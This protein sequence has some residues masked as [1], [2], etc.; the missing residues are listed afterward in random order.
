MPQ[1]E[2]LTIDQS[3]TPA[4]GPASWI[5]TQFIGAPAWEAQCGA[6]K[7]VVSE[8]R[9]RLLYFGSVD[10]SCNLLCCPENT[11]SSS[12]GQPTSNWG[13]HRFWLGPQKRWVWPP[14]SDW[15]FSPAA[16]VSSS[17]GVLHLTHP[18][19]ASD[20]PTIT[21]EYAFEAGRLRCTA[22]WKDD[23]RLYYG[24]HVIAVDVPA[25]FTFKLSKSQE[26]P[27]GLVSVL[28]D[29]YDTRSLG[30]HP[31][32]REMNGLGELVSGTS[33]KAKVGVFPQP[34]QIRREGGWLLSL[35]PGPH[36]GAAVGCSDSG[37][38]SQV[39]V[40]DT[41]CVFAEMEQISPFLAGDGMGQCSS[42][43]YLEAC[44]I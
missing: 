1:C 12:P 38:L 14:L 16:S 20:Y 8:A 30:L 36:A 15:E 10:G 17:G 5:S 31:A 3:A 39:W 40:G 44:K 9:A 24:M 28:L 7:A 25:A 21:R 11:T 35:H 27:A 37:F 33:E 32:F 29:G 34:L 18:S 43:C 41:T 6:V 26:R 2:S 19:T 42:T 4:N 13:G 22:S 23:A